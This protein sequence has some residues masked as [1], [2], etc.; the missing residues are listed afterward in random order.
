MATSAAALALYM[1]VYDVR[2]ETVRKLQ[3][4]LGVNAGK[5]LISD[6]NSDVA[7]SSISYCRVTYS[8]RELQHKRSWDTDGN[9]KLTFSFYPFWCQ[10]V[11]NEKPLDTKARFFQPLVRSRNKPTKETFNYWLTSVAQKRLCL[12]SLIFPVLSNSNVIMFT[13]PPVLGVLKVIS[14]TTA[15]NS[16][17]LCCSQPVQ[18]ISYYWIKLRCYC[19]GL[20]FPAIWTLRDNAFV[21]VSR[22]WQSRQ[23]LPPCLLCWNWPCRC[24]GGCISISAKLKSLKRS[25]LVLVL[26]S[27]FPVSPGHHPAVYR[28]SSHSTTVS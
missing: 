10:H 11:Y 2:T 23:Y 19:K 17:Y 20:S 1:G 3:M 16:R 6:P 9:R 12:S 22:R 21:T 27:F 5:A 24:C 26:Y 7:G 25:S 8:N 4:V 15:N 14:K 28:N 13:T 18:Q